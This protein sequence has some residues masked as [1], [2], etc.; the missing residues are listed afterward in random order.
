MVKFPLHSFLRLLNDGTYV[1]IAVTGKG[2]CR[3]TLRA[4]SIVADNIAKISITDGIS[5]FF[6]TLGVLGIGVGVTIAAFFVCEENEYLAKT[7]TNPIIVT[8]VAGLIAF[9]V[10]GIY[11]SMIDLSAQSI[12]QCYFIDHEFCNGFPRYARPQFKEIILLEP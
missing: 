7:L 4:Y 11:L 1:Q 3:S 9:V 2:Y 12:I 10:A 8:I 5:M 6:T